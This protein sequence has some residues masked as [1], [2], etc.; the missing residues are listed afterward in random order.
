MKH[1]K[2]FVLLLVLQILCACNPFGSIST[3]TSRAPIPVPTLSTTLDPTHANPVSVRIDWN[4]EVT[5]FDVT[6][7]V[8]T[9][10][11]AQN[12]TGGG[13]RYFIEV[14]PTAE[15]L[16]TVE[17]VADAA[18]SS[19][20]KPSLADTLSFTFDS[21]P[22]AV[23]IEQVGTDP[24]GTFPIDFSVVFDE[25]I[26][27]ATLALG[28]FT[29]G[30]TA[31]GVTWALLSA[32]DGQNF[33]LRA[34]AVS[35]NMGTLVPSLA[36]GRALDLAGNGNTGSTSADNA[37]S[38]FLSYESLKLWITAS[39][40]SA[41]ADGAVV[42][43]WQDLSPAANNPTAAINRPSYR[44]AAGAT[45]AYVNF[46]NDDMMVSQSN[47]GIT[48]N[49][50]MEIFVV[51]RLLSNGL[52]F[53]FPVFLQFGLDTGNGRSAWFGLKNYDA[54]VFA[55]FLNG[56]NATVG[57][58]PAG[59]ALYSWSRDS[60][61]GANTA[62][63]GNSIYINAVSQATTNQLL[64]PAVNITD[65]PFWVGRSTNAANIHADICEILVF[66]QTKFSAPERQRIEN[67]LN[68]RY[69]LF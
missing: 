69:T 15:G 53:N 33:T 38:Y 60:G 58:Y 42:G 18:L 59:F 27:T 28:D 34:S 1:S 47:T 37:V 9:N 62:R 56:G 52:P 32:G 57:N 46:D 20:N 64:D 35:G 30:G 14:V 45:P 50:D 23:A 25:P 44:A 7:F 8:V 40:L 31:S 66:N 54:N 26:D 55:G 13:L 4:V 16:V 24:T 19:S 63:S 51:A 39:S 22:P 43:N 61:G 12:L 68:A 5:D 67:Y 21:T 6:D 41:L 10:G 2:H 29:M 65:G 11:T 49:P 17:L 3:L 48:G 36:A